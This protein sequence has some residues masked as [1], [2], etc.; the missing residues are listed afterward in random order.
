MIRLPTEAA[1][2]RRELLFDTGIYSD[3]EILALRIE[4]ITLIVENLLNVEQA[5]PPGLGWSGCPIFLDGRSHQRKAVH[6]T[7]G[8]QTT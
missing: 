3:C 5:A 6:V 8:N 2:L 7:G 1:L 4:S